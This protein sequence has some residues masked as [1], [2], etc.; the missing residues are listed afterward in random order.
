MKKKVLKKVSYDNPFDQI[1]IAKHFGIHFIMVDSKNVHFKIK[2]I[3]NCPMITF[4]IINF[5][6]DF[7]F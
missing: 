5:N 4:I 7:S 1:S 6:S 3:R 2:I